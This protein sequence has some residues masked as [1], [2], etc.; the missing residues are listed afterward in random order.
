MP[1]YD[2]AKTEE[3][4]V[5][6]IYP[7]KKSR[8][9]LLFLADFFLVFIFGITLYALAVYP[10]GDL[11]FN[12]EAQQTQYVEDANARDS[13]LYG[14]SLLLYDQDSSQTTVYY[15]STNLEYTCERFAE[16]Y[17]V[18]DSSQSYEV[19]AHYY[20]D[21]EGDEDTYLGLFTDLDSK[22]SFFDLTGSTPVLKDSYKNYFS[23]LF[24]PG[25]SL[26][27]AGESYYSSFQ[28]D[29]F[30][31]FYSEMLTSI[32]KNDLT[33]AGVSYVEMQ[34]AVNAY[35]SNYDALVI[36]CSMISYLLGVFIV[37]GLFPLL[38]KDRKT[39]SMLALR[40]TRL[41]SS[42]LILLKKR[43]IPVQLVY[44]M[45]FDAA[46]LMFIPI[47]SIS[48][49]YLFSLSSLFILS[50]VSLGLILVSTIFFAADPYGRTLGDRLSFS[51]VVDE[52]TM[53]QIYRAKGYE[54]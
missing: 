48:F 1:D 32:Q 50:L 26:T 34:N 8:R 45:A 21:I 19:F 28:N 46:S 31:R 17:V 39:L 6:N 7:L 11:I 51:V 33:Y 10:L 37:H 40:Y 23:A 4:K 36:G 5:V 27:E 52:E 53:E 9:A 38:N 42:K 22:T 25:D 44:A 16:Y 24:T 47:V 13:V 29:F 30:L 3:P 20:L 15:Y 41:D 49:N 43:Q 54:V 14:N 2:V 18:D 35:L 12:M